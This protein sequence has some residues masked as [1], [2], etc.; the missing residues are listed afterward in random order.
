MVRESLVERNMLLTTAPHYVQALE[1]VVPVKSVW[2][3]IVGSAARF[4]GV[5]A[6]IADRGLPSRR[7]G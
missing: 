3:G 5:K 7:R 2:G 6:R 4:F 1:C